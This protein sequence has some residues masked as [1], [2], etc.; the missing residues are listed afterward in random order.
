MT[1]IFLLTLVYLFDIIFVFIWYDV[2]NQLLVTES[3]QRVTKMIERAW[4]Q[5]TPCTDSQKVKISAYILECLYSP[6]RTN[7]THPDNRK[8]VK[9]LEKN[10]WANTKYDTLK[11]IY[12][13]DINFE[14]GNVA[15]HTLHLL[16]LFRKYPCTE[17][18]SLIKEITIAFLIHDLSEKQLRDHSQAEGPKTLEFKKQEELAWEQETELVFSDRLDIQKYALDIYDELENKESWLYTTLK[19]YENMSHLNWWLSLI[20]Q[21]KMSYEE[22]IYGV[23]KHI[24]KLLKRK[25]NYPCID[26]YL[27]DLQKKNVFIY[28]NFWN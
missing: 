12:E 1:R 24:D 13:P 6:R 11:D 27:S 20:Q 4:I 26:Q 15:G 25:N 16:D 14:H 9:E 10:R 3:V 18:V 19:V 8:E 7:N 2:M 5:M 28:N 22:E 23:Q 17:D 21:Q